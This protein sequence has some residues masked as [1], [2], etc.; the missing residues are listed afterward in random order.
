MDVNV[1]A[2]GT[3]KD[4]MLNVAVERIVESRGKCWHAARAIPTSLSH[5][6]VST[7]AALKVLVRS[8]RI[9]RNVASRPAMRQGRRKPRPF[10][11]HIRTVRC[12]PTTRACILHES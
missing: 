5:S 3:A 12:A 8:R 2:T 6:E 11:K 9:C 4:A 10:S 7:E 1:M